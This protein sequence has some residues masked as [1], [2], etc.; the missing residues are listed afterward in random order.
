MKIVDIFLGILPDLT[1]VH[2]HIQ[3][4]VINTKNVQYGKADKYA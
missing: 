2:D 4:W 1:P 3:W